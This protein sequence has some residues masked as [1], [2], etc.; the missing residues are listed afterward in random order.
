MVDPLDPRSL[1]D[2]K[3]SARHSLAIE[4]RTAASLADHL[5]ITQPMPG[6]PPG[7][8][9]A[10]NFVTARAPSRNRNFFVAETSLRLDAQLDARVLPASA[11]TIAGCERMGDLMQQ[12]VAHLRL[13]IEHRQFPR[14]RDHLPTRAAR[15][16]ATCRPIEIKLPRREAMIL[17]EPARQLLSRDQIHRRE[18]VDE[19]LLI[20]N[21]VICIDVRGRPF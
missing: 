9:L 10:A 12:R 16:E 21:R 4:H 18:T 3:P 14:E 5:P 7:T 6:V 15:A 8:V 2:P 17:H 1:A 11:M 13:A 19:V 20:S